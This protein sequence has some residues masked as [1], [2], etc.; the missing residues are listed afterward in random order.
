[1]TGAD[2]IKEYL[3][4]LGVQVDTPAYMK[5]K[6]ALT[7]IDQTIN[8]SAMGWTRAFGL[9]GTAIVG[10]LGA[11]LASTVAM[12]R[13]VSDSDIVFQKFGRQML[14]NE[15]AAKSLKIATL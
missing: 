2:V 11:I 15:S 7:D 12:M 6:R 3:V 10:T 1:M 4:S 14:I 9:A 13:K 5:L 8:K